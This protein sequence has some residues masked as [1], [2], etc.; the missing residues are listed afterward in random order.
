MTDPGSKES[1]IVDPAEPKRYVLSSLTLLETGADDSVLPVLKKMV[2]SGEINLTS[3]I[4]TH[5]HG[6]HAG[7]NREI[8][9]PPSKT[10]CG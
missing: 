6:D 4:T 3:I 5:H 2:E 8:V 10:T 7:G 1:A 9:T